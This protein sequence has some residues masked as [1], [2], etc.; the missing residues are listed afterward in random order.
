MEV[1]FNL[2]VLCPCKLICKYHKFLFLLQLYILALYFG[3]K[4]NSNIIVA[5]CLLAVCVIVIYYYGFVNKTFCDKVRYL[6]KSLSIDN[7]LM[8]S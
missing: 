8:N 7:P 5:L 6:L 1:L 3:Y 2:G 4:A